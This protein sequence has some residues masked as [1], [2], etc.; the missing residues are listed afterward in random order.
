MEQ[1]TE[2]LQQMIVPLDKMDIKFRKT[3]THV[4]TEEVVDNA[5]NLR[6]DEESYV[7]KWR[8]GAFGDRFIREGDERLKTVLQELKIREYVLLPS[9]DL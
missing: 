2:F 3:L 1:L 5:A 9:L 7:H 6:P 4:A 8:L